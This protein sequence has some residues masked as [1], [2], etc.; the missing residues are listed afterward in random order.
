MQDSATKIG[1]LLC[2]AQWRCDEH[3]SIPTHE[4]ERNFALFRFD[5]FPVLTFVIGG[6]KLAFCV[7]ANLY[8]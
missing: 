8:W 2:T 5:D 7:V 4:Q 3:D 6:M 1:F